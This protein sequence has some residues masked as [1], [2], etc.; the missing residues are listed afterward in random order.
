M[1]NRMSVNMSHPHPSGMT[2]LPKEEIGVQ[3]EH[4]SQRLASVSKKVWLRN[5]GIPRHCAGKIH[6]TSKYAQETRLAR[7]VDF[8]E[9]LLRRIQT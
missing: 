2:H 6:L 8:S 4:D 9:S 7:H 5:A 1:L 3:N